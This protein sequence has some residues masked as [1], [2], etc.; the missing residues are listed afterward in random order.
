ID[1]DGRRGFF[2]FEFGPTTAYGSA[3]TEVKAAGGADPQAV[4]AALSGLTAGTTFH[5][6]L[7]GRTLAGG[8]VNGGDP[9]VP[10]PAGPG[11]ALQLTK[12]SFNVKFIV[13]KSSGQIVLKGTSAVALTA[14]VKLQRDAG[15]G[16]LRPVKTYANVKF[17]KGAFTVKLKAPVTLLP[18]AHV[19]QV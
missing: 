12:A 18:G 8:V 9:T 3:T 5:Y 7:V 17:P 2:H 13:S 19:V 16:K 1:T 6:R 10:H 14:T 11:H 15:G 4:T